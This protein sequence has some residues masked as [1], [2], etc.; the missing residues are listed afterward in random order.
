MASYYQASESLPGMREY[1]EWFVRHEKL[2][3]AVML[4]LMIALVVQVKFCHTSV[5]PE[6]RN[7][8]PGPLQQPSVRPSDV[9]GKWGMSVQKRKGGVQTWILTLEQSGE[10]LSGVIHSEGGA[11]PV[12][13]TI[14]A[15]SI[16]LSAE[17]FGATVEFPATLNGDTL[18]GTMRVLMVTRQWTA[19]RQ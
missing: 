16:N 15:Q 13:G 10:K 3:V 4:C 6:V 19:K 5:T 14:E 2:V 11:L 9:A 1:F 12:S 18:T 8:R 7:L 17:R